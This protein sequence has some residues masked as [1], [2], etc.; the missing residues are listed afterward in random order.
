MHTPVY[1]SFIYYYINVRFKGC[2]FHVFFVFVF[3]DVTI[4][5]PS[6]VHVFRPDVLLPYECNFFSTKTYD[7]VKG[8]RASDS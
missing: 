8:S 5:S 1:P 3:T 4:S 6:R 2:N 7:R